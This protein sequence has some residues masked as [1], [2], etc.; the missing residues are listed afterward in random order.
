[1]DPAGPCFEYNSE[2]NR[3][4]LLDAHYVDIIH[5]STTFGYHGPIGHADFY[6]NNGHRQPG[7][8]LS[9]RSAKLSQALSI[10]LCGQEVNYATNDEDIDNFNASNISNRNLKQID[11]STLISCTHS[12][13]ITYFTQSIQNSCYF[14]AYQCS[15][16]K[17][18]KKNR[19]SSC[20]T[21]HMGFYSQKPDTPTY[22]YLRVS[23]GA[24]QPNCLSSN[25]QQNDTI[26]DNPNPFCLNLSTTIQMTFLSNLSLFLLVIYTFFLFL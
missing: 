6:P 5:S 12:K 7:C 8:L 4:N 3:L 20:E 23:Q 13:A 11:F 19:C 21:N 2:A 22:Y 16:W 17:N 15:N 26:S 14:L 25:Q 10:V 24:P 1:M 9:K 18:F